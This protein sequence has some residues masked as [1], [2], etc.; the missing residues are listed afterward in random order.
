MS[1]GKPAAGRSGHSPKAYFVGIMRGSFGG[2]CASDSPL[3]RAKWRVT[4]CNLRASLASPCAC[5]TAAAAAW[6]NEVALR[7]AAN[8]GRGRKK[9]LAN[10]H[11]WR[12][13]PPAEAQVH[14]RR[15]LG[16]PGVLRQALQPF[17]EVLGHGSSSPYLQLPILAPSMDGRSDSSGIRNL[18]YPTQTMQTDHLSQIVYEGEASPIAKGRT[19]GQHRN[20]LR[21]IVQQPSEVWGGQNRQRRV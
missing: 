5:L 14:A 15:E 10:A 4:L 1:P 17:G 19:I 7:V 9:Y 13:T 18:I 8:Y 6:F 2:R 20:R 11:R 3:R 12:S 16:V 21:Q